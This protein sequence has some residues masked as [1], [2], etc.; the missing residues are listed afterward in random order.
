MAMVSPIIGH[1]SI[2]SSPFTITLAA[3]SPQD[4]RVNYATQDGTAVANLDYLPKSGTV[5]IPS[6]QTSATVSVQ[7]LGNPAISQD[8]TF[9]LNL[10]N[11]SH[12]FLVVAGATCT[13]THN[14]LPALS[15]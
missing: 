5:T 7:V 6:G 3:T 15:M 12:G 11:P 1:S 10:S 9:S 4:V 8:K 2:L 13:L 14:Q